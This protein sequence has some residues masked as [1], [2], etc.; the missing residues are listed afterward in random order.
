MHIARP[1]QNEI[2][3]KEE[4]IRDGNNRSTWEAWEEKNVIGPFPPPFDG[5]NCSVKTANGKCF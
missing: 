3:R 2:E 5:S 1:K 4:L